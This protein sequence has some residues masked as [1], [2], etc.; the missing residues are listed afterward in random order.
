M[1]LRIQKWGNSLAVRLPKPLATQAHMAEGSLVEVTCTD[2]M[3][4]LKPV[5]RPNYT[6]EE[7]LADVTDDNRHG[8][9]DMGGSQGDEVW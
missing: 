6:L 2:G 1:Q 4:V 7:L 8:E 5:E 9:V 3:L